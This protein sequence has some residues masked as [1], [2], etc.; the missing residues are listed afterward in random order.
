MRINAYDRTINTTNGPVAV[1]PDPPRHINTSRI[2]EE[3]LTYTDEP[4]EVVHVLSAVGYAAVFEDGH[5]EDLVFWVVDDEG[6][7]CGVTL[8]DEGRADLASVEGREGF[9]RYER[10]SDKETI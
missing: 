1:D 8:N 10:T 2:V 9:V 6:E 3:D 4:A 7:V 5:R